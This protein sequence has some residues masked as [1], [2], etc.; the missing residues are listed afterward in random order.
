MKIA[1]PVKDY[2]SEAALRRGW[3]TRAQGFECSKAAFQPAYAESKLHDAMLA[4]A[5]A[6]LWP[7]VCSNSL[8]PGW[9]PTKMGGPRGG[10]G[11]S[12][13]GRQSSQEIYDQVHD[14]I[15]RPEQTGLGI[16]D[17][18]QV[19]VSRAVYHIA[20]ASNSRRHQ[21]VVQDQ[22]LTG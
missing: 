16:A 15:R 12:G 1:Q 19:S 7:D 2:Y 18:G 13:P 22:C 3:P 17:E 10:H 20:G 6:R 21:R 11:K 8:E 5:V 4:F 14:L 9:V